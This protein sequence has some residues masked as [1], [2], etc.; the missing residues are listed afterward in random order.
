M[1]KI[2]LAS[3]N[4]HKIEELR[5]ILKPLDIDLLSTSDFPDLQEVIEDGTTLQE[6]ALK[7][8]RYVANETGLPSLADDTGLEVEALDMRPGV[9]SARYA[10]EDVTYEDNVQ[11]LLKELRPFKDEN[12]R[13]AQFRTVIAFIKGSSVEYFEGICK[14]F[15]INR[16]K[17][18]NGFGYDPV[19]KPEGYEQT[20]AELDQ[21]E[22]NR[23]SHRGQ[24]VQKFYV[25]LEK[26]DL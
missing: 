1:K 19:F 2:V 25:W 11:K 20:F 18:E 4:P 3:R 16:P 13:K 5:Q 17:G 12:Q 8:A 10:G 22:K 24:A 21:V 7:K 23:I 14:G 26:N 9:Y 15:I 6:N